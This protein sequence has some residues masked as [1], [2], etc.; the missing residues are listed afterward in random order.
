MSNRFRSLALITLAVLVVS[1]MGRAVRFQ[2]I[3]ELLESALHGSDDSR[4]GKRRPANVAPPV[5]DTDQKLKAGPQFTIYQD[6]NGEIVCRDATTAERREMGKPDLQGLG[7]R[8][9]NHLD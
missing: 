6:E 8:P 3:S 4:A 2:S 5:Q 1:A 7:M 9:I